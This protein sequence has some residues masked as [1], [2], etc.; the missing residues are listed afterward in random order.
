MTLEELTKETEE[1]LDIVRDLSK[2]VLY[3][4][5][6][7][8]TQKRITSFVHPISY[9]SSV[10]KYA[11]KKRSIV[12]PENIASVLTPIEIAQELKKRGFQGW[13][14]R[15]RYGKP[16]LVKELPNPE[17]MPPSESIQKEVDRVRD[18]IHEML[19]YFRYVVRVYIPSQTVR[20]DDIRDL[21]A[22]E[23]TEYRSYNRGL[24]AFFED[25]EEGKRELERV[26][27]LQIP[28]SSLEVGYVI[29][30]RIGRITKGAKKGALR[31]TIS[32]SGIYPLPVKSRRLGAV[33]LTQLDQQGIDGWR[34]EDIWAHGILFLK[35]FE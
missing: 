24:V 8:K 12:D 17:Y 19:S 10:Q 22:R 3:T 13:N 30:R 20:L 31:A 34:I 32:L 33:I 15:T 21:L 4:K 11:E 26:R 1:V 23:G 6:V 2:E 5:W 9:N 27:E 18:I 29:T 35:Q 16:T 28:G 14:L 7:V 25:R